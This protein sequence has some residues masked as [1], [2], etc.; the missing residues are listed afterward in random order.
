MQKLVVFISII[1]L[2]LSS[3]NKE[4]KKDLNHK[5]YTIYGSLANT[6]SS[7]I[8]LLNHKNVIIDSSK[9][10][11]NTF[12]FKGFLNTP[13]IHQI[14]IKNKPKTHLIV[15]E[16]SLYNVLLTN[17][18]ATISG[19]DLN[20]K[21]VIFNTSKNNLNN[22]KLALLETFMIDGVNSEPL[23]KSVNTLNS[24]QKKATTDFIIE[25]SK[26]ILSSILFK[27][28]KDFT[29]LELKE[30]QNNSKIVDATN[31]KI[32]LAEEINRL[33]TEANTKLEEEKLLEE[34]RI[35]A[36]K[37]T[38]RKPAIMFSGDGLD[39]NLLSLQSIIKNKK[40][41]LIDFWASWCGPCREVT[42]K[43]KEL[44]EKYKS[45]G[46]TIL[47]VSEDKNSED[48]KRG[49][50]QDDMLSWYHIF[51]DYGRISTMHGIRA[52]PYMILIDGNGG[53]IKEKISISELEYQLQQLL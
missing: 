18:N 52:I 16:N 5:G 51:D 1:S 46:F 32:L 9:V 44:Y 14:Q 7:I 40:V 47:T 15:L 17:E 35:K 49:I 45:K 42:P 53:V 36:L 3:C 34:K 43:V 48:W 27:S 2:V 4:V 10:K 13:E 24:I 29:I 6:D 50:K 26:N 28:T 25:N 11:N 21:Q 37:N 39:G 31:L 30:I 20:T 19:G 12:L 33:Q 41:I 22:K 8:Y 38:Y 23:F